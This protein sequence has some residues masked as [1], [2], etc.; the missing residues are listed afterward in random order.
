MKTL[1]FIL[2]S[3]LFLL[4]PT[5]MYASATANKSKS[6]AETSNK[7][8]RKPASIHLLKR[9][10]VIRS[11]LMVPGYIED[12]KLYV[13]FDKPVESEYVVVTDIESGK[14]VYSGTF[15][16]SVLVISLIELSES[17]V[18]EIV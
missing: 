4:H 9:D 12:N 18:V 8:P 15:T 13:C 3:S 5:F 17:Y 2:L 10:R 6:I 14:Q 7:K 11:V 16:G 1:F